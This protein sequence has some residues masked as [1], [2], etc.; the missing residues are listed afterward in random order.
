M[1][2]QTLSPSQLKYNDD[3]SDTNWNANWTYNFAR[4][5]N[6]LLKLSALGDVDVSGLQD[7]DILVYNST[8]QN[9]E[10]H[11]SPPGHEVTTTTTTTT[12]TSTT[13]TTTTT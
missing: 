11:T 10:R 7:G 9:W 5:N 1:T 12:T 4:L 3:E 2:T 13:T 6:T 8:S